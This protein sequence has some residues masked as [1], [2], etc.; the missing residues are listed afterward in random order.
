MS[1]WLKGVLD[2]SGAATSGSNGVKGLIRSR[3]RRPLI[4]AVAPLCGL[5]AFQ[6]SGV[7]CR[8]LREQRIL[9]VTSPFRERPHID[10]LSPTV[11]SVGPGSEITNSI[12]GS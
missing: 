3:K 6:A 9:Y 2:V 10:A 1:F 5:S 8:M 11:R 12:F 4:V 7:G